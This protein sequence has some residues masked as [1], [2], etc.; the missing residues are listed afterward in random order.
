MH[1]DATQSTFLAQAELKSVALGR[2]G[3]PCQMSFM[4]HQGGTDY[5]GFFQVQVR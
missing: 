1:V 5:S 3:I 4:H 2:T